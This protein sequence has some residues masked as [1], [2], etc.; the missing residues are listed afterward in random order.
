MFLGA[1]YLCIFFM[2]FNFT[3]ALMAGMYI[4]G[5]VG[6]APSIASYNVI[7]FGLGNAITFPLAP[8]IANRFGSLAVL[9]IALISFALTIGRTTYAETFFIFNTLH[10]LS[11]VFAGFFLP[12]ALELLDDNLQEKHK[13]LST[14]FI[15]MMLTITPVLG[16]SFGAWIAYDYVWNYIFALQLP[17][18]L[19]AFAILT[20]RKNEIKVPSPKEPF[21]TVGYLSY[22][23]FIIPGV[24]AV[25]LG[26]LL[27]WFRSP[28]VNSFF[29]ISLV[30]GV[31]FILWEL[32]QKNPFMKLHLFKKS[33]FSLAVL[34][35]T[36]LYSAYFG[37]IILL[38]LW[39]HLYVNYTI[40]WISILLL[41]MLIAGGL[42]FVFVLKWAEKIPPF[43]PVTLAFCFFGFS[44]FYSSTFNAETDLL[45]LSIAR[46]FAGFGLAF[47]LAPLIRVCKAAVAKNDEEESVC[48]FHT[49]RL[50]SASIGLSLYITLWERRQ[51]F[52]H[53]RLGAT[54]TQYSEATRQYLLKLASFGLKGLSEKELLEKALLTQASALALADTFY[55]IGWIMVGATILLLIHA[56]FSF[57]KDL[58]VVY[59]KKNTQKS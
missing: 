47:F 58:E 53:E 11:G 8:F 17:L 1:L 3:S 22:L 16:S 25:C 59:R 32:T 19:F 36:L 18:I 35:V 39:L 48:I 2:I 15:S 14:A 31:F 40:I 44:C 4:I 21:D 20:T 37:T 51:I 13:K 56:F 24:L 45:R 12:L 38:G 57:K 23:I 34:L 26:E 33:S 27:D 46:I 29:T 42:L 5:E 6:G 55:F 28:V 49:A 50:L 7:L 43:I 54:L 10:L 30:S 9:R 52:Y 41:H